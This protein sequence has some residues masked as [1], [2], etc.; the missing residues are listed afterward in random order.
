MWAPSGLGC[1]R[2]AG[3]SAQSPGTGRSTWPCFFKSG[4]LLSLSTVLQAACTCMPPVSGSSLHVLCSG[5]YLCSINSSTPA[6]SGRIGGF[7]PRQ[8]RAPRTE[9]VQ[10]WRP[11]SFGRTRTHHMRIISKLSLWKCP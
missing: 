6:E 2:E 5:A 8:L 7:L 9:L 10:N 3:S 11:K 4:T 1:R